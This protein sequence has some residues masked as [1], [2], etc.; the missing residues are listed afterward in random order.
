VVEI[1]DVV[2][3]RYLIT[4]HLGQGGMSLVFNAK[5]KHLD[6]DVA[7]KFLRP[8]LT[9]TDQERFRIEIKTLARLRHSGIVSIYDLGLGDYIYFAMELVDGGMFTDLGPLEIDPAPLRKLIRA[10]ITVAEALAYV[11]KLGIIHRD[12]T[13]KN[14]LLT[15]LYPLASMF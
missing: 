11:H 7:L 13:P 2:D 3:N 6:R 9:D 5:D 1:G 12:L 8:H 14:I 4:G 10:S 15:K